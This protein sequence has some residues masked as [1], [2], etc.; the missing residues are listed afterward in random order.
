MHLEFP[1][2][3]LHFDFSFGGLKGPSRMYLEV[4]RKGQRH[5]DNSLGETAFHHV[6]FH[7]EWIRKLSSS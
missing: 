4:M 2:F 7:L 1:K 3:S 5:K 6:L